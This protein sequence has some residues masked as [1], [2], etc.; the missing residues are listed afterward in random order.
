ADNL[1]TFPAH[2]KYEKLSGTNIDELSCATY[3]KKLISLKGS[4][5]DVQ[6]L[7][8]KMVTNL[9]TLHTNSDVGKT[10]KDR[11]SFLT[12]WARYHVMNL[13]SKNPISNQEKPLLKELNEAIF[14][15]NENITEWNNRCNFYLYGNWDYWKEEKD[16]HDYFVNHDKINEYADRPNGDTPNKYCI[17]LNHI[18]DLYKRYIKDCCMCFIR[19]NFDCE[20]KCPKY[21][22]CEKKYYPY[23]L[24]SKL[25]CSNQK[26]NDTVEEIF[27][28]VTLDYTVVTRSQIESLNSCNSSTCEQE[29]NSYDLI[30]NLNSPNQKPN[31]SV[32]ETNKSVILDHTVLNRSQIELVNSCN[33]F[34]CEPF[35]KFVSLGYS[36]LGGGFIFS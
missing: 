21:F 5:K 6:T 2:E 36:L 31:D 12:H 34:M 29:Y 35:Y 10:Q 15:V 13:F 9:K 23:D 33:S 20:E 18:N 3:C 24:I 1:D 25:K 14:N 16:L 32:E 4:K 30:H 8:A 27:K 17:Y 7:C 22:K 19:P 26:P 11:C 28:P